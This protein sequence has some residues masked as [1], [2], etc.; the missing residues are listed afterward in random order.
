VCC[1]ECCS[2]EQCVAVSVAAKSSML[3]CIKKSYIHEIRGYAHIA[4]LHTPCIL[5][6][7]HMS[8]ILCVSVHYIQ[9]GADP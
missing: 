6:S 5:S 3:Q 8:T 2:E 9:G 4:H 1:S 7:I